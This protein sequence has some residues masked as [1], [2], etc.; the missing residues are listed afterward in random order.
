VLVPLIL[1][2]A[3]VAAD[4]TA[5]KFLLLPP[6]GALTYLLFVN[7]TGVEMNIRR[8]VIAPTATALFAWI[9]ASTAGYNA[10][11]VAAATVGTMAI[12]WLLQ[13]ATMVPPLALALLTVLLYK[14][15]RGQVDYVLSVF[16]FT[17]AI[18]LIHRL[19]LRLPL[20]PSESA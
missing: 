8:V 6:L 5:L 14:V 13:S 10:V 2:L 18:Y 16:I 12:L 15:V 20:D 7:P 11:T 19:W 3:D 1:V 17:A 4:R 9:L